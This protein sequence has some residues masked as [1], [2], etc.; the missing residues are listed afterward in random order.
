MRK[1]IEQ[2]LAI[3]IVILLSAGMTSCDKNQE[4]QLSEE[5]EIQI[6]LDDNDLD[7]EPTESG[8]YY[9]ELIEGTGLQ[10]VAGDTV[11]VHYSGT[12]LNGRVF[13]SNIG[14]EPMRFVLGIAYVI[15]GWEEG[16]TYMKEGGEAL[17]IVPS[18]LAY[19]AEG[20]YD[21]PAY[22]PLAF[23]IILEDVYPGPGR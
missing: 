9:I 22:T 6:F 19:G 15:E 11:T 3:S 13:D 8:L 16:L 23:T 14:R 10:P 18:S 4:V 20:Y 17:L 21:I 7:F 2:L 5:E 12:F 1:K